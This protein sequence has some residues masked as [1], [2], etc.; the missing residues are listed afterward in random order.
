MNNLV[1]RPALGLWALIAV[2]SPSAEVLCQLVAGAVPDWLLWFRL[3]V[4]IAILAVGFL[5]EQART[6]R[7][8]CFAYG[9]QLIVVAVLKAARNSSGGYQVLFSRHSFVGGQLFVFSVL[10]AILAPAIVW[11]LRHPHRFYLRIGDV[12][13]ALEP[14]W[15]RIK[16]RPLRWNVVG[17]VFGLFG[18]ICVWIFLSLEGPSVPKPLTMIPWAIV[19]GSINA[20][21]EEFLYRNAL[22]P[23]VQERFGTQHA[24]IAS[25]AIFG[26]GHWNGLPAGPVGVLMTSALGYVAG[27]AMIETKGTFWPWFMH[28]LPDCV[29]FYYWGI[30]AAAH[31]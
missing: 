4:L 14:A 12:S 1:H 28:A 10:L 23:A 18:A 15:M 5:V 29:L 6:L 7:G 8:F 11:F 24:L 13:A 19:L 25:A 17:P 16:D 31:G 21:T 30:G 2:V 20:F 3:A 27:K 9:F 26:I 22:V